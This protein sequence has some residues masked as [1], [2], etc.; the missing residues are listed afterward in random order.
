MVEPKPPKSYPA[1]PKAP[2][3]QNSNPND[4]KHK[5][6]NENFP[7]KLNPKQLKNLIRPLMITERT[8]ANRIVPVAMRTSRSF[9]WRVGSGQRLNPERVSI[10]PSLLAFSTSSSLAFGYSMKPS[11]VQVR[12]LHPMGFGHGLLH[13][14]PPEPPCLIENPYQ[15]HQYHADRVTL[16]VNRIDSSHFWFI[17]DKRERERVKSVE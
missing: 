17:V 5:Y 10:S 11:S 1:K 9:R 4:P 14:K 15:I 12:R 7:N 2:I 6:P 3:H 8:Q 16:V 13:H